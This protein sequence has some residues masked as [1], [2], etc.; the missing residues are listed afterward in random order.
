MG[1]KEIVEADF[2]IPLCDEY[3]QNLYRQTEFGKVS[4]S[5]PVEVTNKNILCDVKRLIALRAASRKI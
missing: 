1:A 5:L 3:M 4:K 2:L